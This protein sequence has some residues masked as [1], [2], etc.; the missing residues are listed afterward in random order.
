MTDEEFLA[1]FEDLMAKAD[2]IE[3]HRISQI[4]GARTKLDELIADIEPRDPYF[5]DHVRRFTSR[6]SIE[7]A[8]DRIRWFLREGDLAAAE[9][10]ATNWQNHYSHIRDLLML[11]AVKSRDA[12]STGGAKG[13]RQPKRREWA[14][15][16]AQH[17]ALT[18]VSKDEAW[19]AIPESRSPLEFR[20]SDGEIEVYRDGETIV[21][22]AGENETTL[23]RSTFFKRYFPPSGQQAP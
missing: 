16:L 7:I 6:P 4:E 8:V 11:A 14:D 9:Q 15:T 20:S 19:D 12:L 17:L 3:K 5:A 22:A 23:S 1:K 10:A 21:C 2:Y 18:A 13:G